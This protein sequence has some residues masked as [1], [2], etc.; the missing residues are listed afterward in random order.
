MRLEIHRRSV[1]V[2]AFAFVLGFT[3]VFVAEG[4]AASAIGSA[5]IT[6][7]GFLGR[8]VGALVIVLGLNML[9]VFRLR[10]LAMDRRLRFRLGR[11]GY[12]GS[13]IAGIGFAAGWTPCIGPILAAVLAMAGSARTVTSGTLLLVVYSAGLAV[14]FSPW[15][16]DYSMPCRRW[17]GCDRFSRPSSA[18]LACS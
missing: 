18:L 9:G 11:F 14:P 16:S 1:V 6:W 8:A 12:A 13:T 4:A 10:F 5:F 17:H 15:R 7:R 3:L 2:H